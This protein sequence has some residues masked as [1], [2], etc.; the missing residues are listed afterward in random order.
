MLIIHTEMSYETMY[1]L[2]EVMHLLAKRKLTCS[3]FFK[4]QR[5][6]E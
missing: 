1:D 2:L 5:P 6:K 4:N 3:P